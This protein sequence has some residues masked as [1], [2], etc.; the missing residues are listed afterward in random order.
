MATKIAI[1]QTHDARA[2]VIQRQRMCLASG[3]R[4]LGAGGSGGGQK[5]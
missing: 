2:P 4:S 1:A 5:R 3:A